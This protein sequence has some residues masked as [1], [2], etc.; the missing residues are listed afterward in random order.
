MQNVA[1]RWT[2]PIFVAMSVLACL[3]G[4]MRA[5][6][7]AQHETSADIEDGA[8]VF[9]NTCA[10]CHGPDGNTIPGIDLG[11]GQFRQPYSDA[12]LS[13][14]IRNGI[15]GTAMPPGNFS[16]EQAA[17]V[18][19][20]LRSVAASH[21]SSV[22]AGD[23]QRGR[24][25]FEGKG[26]CLNCHRVDGVGAGLGPELTSIGQMRRA[27]ELEQSLLDPQ[28]EVLPWHRFYRVVTRDGF[29]VTGRLL[30][31]DTFTVQL[32]DLNER[33]RSFAKADLREY[34]FAPTP[35]PSYRDTLTAQEVADVVSYLVSL[36]GRDAP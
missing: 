30:S 36:K 10:T 24:A 25:I 5:T 12:D 9:R 18:V 22:V 32:L 29:T 21:R 1:E 35:M 28:A 14:I 20:Y 31:L 16:E 15:P 6:S 3:A 8:R 2:T 23:A 13:R 7:W 17:R 34:D 11:R 26:T 4:P 19:A 33:L 27:V